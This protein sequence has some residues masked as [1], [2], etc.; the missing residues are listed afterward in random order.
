MCDSKEN[1]LIDCIINAK[2]AHPVSTGS[3]RIILTAGVC[4]SAGTVSLIGCGES[5]VEAGVWLCPPG[6]NKGRRKRRERGD[7][8]ARISQADKHSW[9]SHHL[10]LQD[11]LG[12]YFFEHIRL[13]YQ[14]L[15][16]CPRGEGLN[17]L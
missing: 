9:L 7:D 11:K 6:M 5:V 3:F 16:L 17:I 1:T 4:L 14:L 12:H 2:R 13:F 10:H 15:S 8:G